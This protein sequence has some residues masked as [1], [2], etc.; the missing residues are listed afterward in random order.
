M[1]RLFILRPTFSLWRLDG[2]ATQ[3]MPVVVQLMMWWIVPQLGGKKWI[4][5]LLER[6]SKKLL[7]VEERSWGRSGC[8]LFVIQFVERSF[9]NVGLRI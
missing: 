9:R 3:F 1:L 6:F 5:K 7:E 4:Q 2:I 8:L